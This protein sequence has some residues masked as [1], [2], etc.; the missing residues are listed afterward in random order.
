[1]LLETREHS[2]SLIIINNVN[3]IINNVAPVTLVTNII[4][5]NINKGHDHYKAT[6]F[7]QEVIMEDG[8]D[9]NERNATSIL[10]ADEFLKIGLKLVGFKR[11]RIRRAKKKTNIDRFVA[12]YGS[13]PS[14]C[15]IIWED[16]Q[17]TEVEEALVP[18]ENLNV[19]FFLMAMHH[20]KRYP[21]SMRR[22]GVLFIADY[23]QVVAVPPIV[24]SSSGTRTVERCST[25]STQAR[26]C[27]R[28]C[29]A[30]SS[31]NL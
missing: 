17:T 11:R 16:L 13:I 4:N 1:L 24:Q 15:A 20:L 26:K 14:I 6:T 23:W 18:A 30:S 29:G 5:I 9:E 31:E 27:V 21:T 25:R 22:T 10:T 7:H 8:N 2:S 28:F 12:H 3:I 19:K